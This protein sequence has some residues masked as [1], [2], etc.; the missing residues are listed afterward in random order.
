MYNSYGI[1]NAISADGY[2]VNNCLKK[3]ITLHPTT[4]ELKSITWLQNVAP[5]L[6]HRDNCPWYYDCALSFLIVLNTKRC[7][8]LGPIFS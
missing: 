2:I 8:L 3:S 1:W 4:E 6:L 7:K 5:V